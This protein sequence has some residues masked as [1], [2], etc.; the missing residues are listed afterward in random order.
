MPSLLTPQV[1]TIILGNAKHRHR[2]R[3]SCFWGGH[4]NPA[5]HKKE[6]LVRESKQ[7]LIVKAKCQFVLVSVRSVLE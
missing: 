7:E 6:N 2:Y 4:K 5:D 3:P 1:I